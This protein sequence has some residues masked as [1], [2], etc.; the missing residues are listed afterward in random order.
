MDWTVMLWVATI[1]IFGY[2]FFIVSLRKGT[3]RQTWEQA[4]AYVVYGLLAVWLLAVVL[5]ALF[6]R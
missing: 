3:K 5:M 1:P 4:V 6:L 2:L